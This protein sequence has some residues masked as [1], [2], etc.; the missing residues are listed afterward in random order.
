M[1]K[2]ILFPFEISKDNYLKYATAMKM[3]GQYQLPLICFTALSADSKES[4]EDE[5]YL[6]LLRL[7]G[8][9]QTHFNAWQ[10]GKKVDIQRVVKRGV[11]QNQ[12]QLF[13]EHA[14]VELV[15][16]QQSIAKA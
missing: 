2:A 4:D 15:L 6:H 5:V 8:F 13:I 12:L 16:F 11:F 9:Y 7:N 3:A 14:K 10:P 1:R